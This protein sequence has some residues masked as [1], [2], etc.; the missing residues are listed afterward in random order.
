[1]AGLPAWVQTLGAMID[2]DAHVQ[3]HC[4]QCLVYR[5]FTRA[6]LEALAAKVG[7]GYSLVN[8]R[9][10]CRLTKGCQGWN[11]FDYLLGIYRP[12][13]DRETLDRWILR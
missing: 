9:C 11:S 8:R 6:D 7:R 5:R 3:V 1:M 13:A 4:G 10:R 2:D 12:L